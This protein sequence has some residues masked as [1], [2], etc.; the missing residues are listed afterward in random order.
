MIFR[1]FYILILFIFSAFGSIAQ[2][3]NY[4]RKI[5]DTLCSESMHGRGFV[6]D[7][8]KIAANYIKDRYSEAKLKF[9]TDD[10]FQYFTVSLNVLPKKIFFKINNNEL[11]PA[12]DYLVSSASPSTKGTFKVV[13]LNKDVISNEQKFE[14][15]KSNNFYDKVLIV[16]RKGVED[17]VQRELFDALKYYN[18]FKAKG[19]INIVDGKLSW[20]LSDAIQKADYFTINLLREKYIDTVK[21]VTV[22]INSSYYKNYKTQNVIGYISGK[23]KPDSFIVFTAHY[24]HL[25]QM[26]ENVYFPGANDN[27]CGV[28]ASLD[29]AKFYSKPEN[30]QEYSVAFIAFSGEETGLFGSKYFCENPLFPLDKIKFLINLDVIGTGEDGI[31]VVNGTKFEKE[32]NAIVKIN[33]EKKYFKT[34]NKRGEAANSDHYYFYKNGVK[35]VF[36]YTMGGK[37]EGHSINDNPGKLPMTKYNELF[38][39][40][41]EFVST[42]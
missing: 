41:T 21:E 28:A 31:T 8:D 17:T 9:F 7:G 34:V 20:R 23:S 18:I 35:A 36:I 29:L 33:D 26:G 2:D 27:A 16:D 32:F 5:I 13:T 24:D 14:K 12:V 15:F 10:Y 1:V 11:V 22:D 42:F 19:I 25:G 37:V 30:Q 4:A 38:K 39:L 40:I 6:N 3:I